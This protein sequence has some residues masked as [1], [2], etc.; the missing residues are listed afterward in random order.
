MFICVLSS[1]YWGMDNDGYNSRATPEGIQVGGKIDPMGGG[2]HHS[3]S[4]IT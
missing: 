4:V 3:G 2:G 1:V